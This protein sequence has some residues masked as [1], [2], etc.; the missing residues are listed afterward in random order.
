MGGW[1]VRPSDWGLSASVE[2]QLFR[3]TS[4]EVGY[5]RRWLENFTVTDNLLQSAADLT[6]FS[7][8]APSDPRLPGGGG[9][10]VSGLYN[11]V[12][13]VVSLANNFNTLASNY[14]QQYQYSNT[15]LVDVS[16]RLR[17]RVTLKASLSAWDTV[18]DNC[19]VRSKI[20]ELTTSVGPLVSPTVP[21]CH[22]DSGL[23]WRATALA[24]YVIPTIDLQVSGTWRSD[25]G[26]PLA[27]NYSVPTATVA[28]QGPQPLGRPL[29]N[30]A[31]FAV[32]NLIAPGTM[33]GDRV[34]EL[35]LKLAKILKMGR[36]HVNGGVEMYNALNSSAVLGYNPTFVPGGTWLRPTAILTPRF[37][38]LTAQLDF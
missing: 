31:S 35:N 34:N 37:V 25:Q 20:P 21:Y 13:S 4:I 18:Q 26:A 3:Q 24:A 8:V 2:Q 10:V 12:Q 11:P 1:G 23:I 7:I 27:A 28:T 32:V 14:G 22:V 15:L 5:M 6:P 33:Y 30:G 36:T 29:S 9:Y 16:S 19:E 17:E 38:K